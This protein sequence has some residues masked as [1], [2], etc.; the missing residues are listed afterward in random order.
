[1]SAK[2]RCFQSEFSFFCRSGILQ[3]GLRLG[4]LLCM[5]G[6]LE[7]SAWA[8]LYSGSVTGVV[9]DPSGAVV[10]GA[11]VTLTDVGKG[12]TFPTETDSV[13]RYVLRYF[14]SRTY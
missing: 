9:T 11:N 12:F 6:F 2:I 8:Q 14:P 10:P 1:V 13:G 7:S 3:V 4:L 5:A